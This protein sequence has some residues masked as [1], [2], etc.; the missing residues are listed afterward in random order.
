MTTVTRVRFLALLGFGFF[1]AAQAPSKPEFI[2]GK[3]YTRQECLRIA[4]W[5]IQDNKGFYAL[6]GTELGNLAQIL[7]DCDFLQFNETTSHPRKAEKA[8]V[9]TALDLA[10][11]NYRRS[12]EKVIMQLPEALRQKVLDDLSRTTVSSN[13]SNDIPPWSPFAKDCADAWQLMANKP[14]DW[15]ATDPAEKKLLEKCLTA[16]EGNSAQQQRREQKH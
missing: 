6:T 12:L 15:K 2:G 10:S 5:V 9:T 4:R 8:D 16:F 1:C 3:A 14:K 11:F 7:D 13:H